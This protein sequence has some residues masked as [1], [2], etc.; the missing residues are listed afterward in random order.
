MWQTA[1][2]CRISLLWVALIVSRLSLFLCQWPYWIFGGAF[3]IWMDALCNL[4]RTVFERRGVEGYSEEE[5]NGRRTLLREGANV[6]KFLWLMILVYSF[7]IGTLI[8]DNQSIRMVFFMGFFF[9]IGLSMLPIV[10]FFFFFFF[11]LY[12]YN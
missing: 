1:L 7:Y 4:A 6:A 10:S 3:I 2:L 5:K 11:F 12:C 8:G 9:S